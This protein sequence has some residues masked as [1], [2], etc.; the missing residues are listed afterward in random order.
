[1]KKILFI[2]P[3]G[4]GD[5]LFTM[6]LVEA[7]RCAEPEAEIAFLCNERTAELVRLN[8]SIDHTFVFHRD[9]FRGLWKNK[10]TQFFREF[11]G[12]WQRIRVEKYDTL[13][14]LSLGREFSFFSMLVG[15]PRRIGLDYK[16]RGIFLTAKKKI[17][18]Y[19]GEPVAATQL[20]LL[21]LAGFETPKNNLVPTLAISEQVRN[22]MKQSFRRQGVAE[23]EKVL[24]VAPGGGRSWGKDAIYKQWDPGRFAQTAKAWISQGRRKTAFFG[25]AE[26]SD[27]VI[28]AASA[29]PAK[30]LVFI[31]LSMEKLCAALLS[32]D[33]LLCNDSGLLHLANAL[34]VKTVSIF[35]PVD[36]KVY[37]PFW[38]EAPH[39]VITENVPCRPC[40]SR[41]HFP[42]CPHERRCLE[43]LGV[44][45]VVSAIEKMA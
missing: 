5:V 2:N 14:D 44:E 24:G 39:E 19:E 23:G 9:H 8:Q 35:G 11:A 17:L 3:F 21:G 13:F 29:T 30:P 10:K 4:I 37:G 34:G 22:E 18:G 26:E 20:S 41:F 31:D 16:N 15:I 36:E 28:E 32:C 33:I 12:F 40:Y 27:L 38:K 7:V 6:A 45:K 25:D 1:M 43:A 42:P